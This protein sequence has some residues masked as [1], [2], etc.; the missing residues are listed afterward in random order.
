[1]STPWDVYAKELGDAC[2][3]GY[4]LWDPEPEEQGTVCIGDVG[5]ISEGRFRRL[6]NATRPAN[7]PL[8]TLFGV[9][10]GYEPLQIK[11]QLFEDKEPRMLRVGKSLNSNSITS[12]QVSGG[13]SG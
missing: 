5:Y 9:P 13:A 10:D 7:D 4:P 11:E 6:F 1:M 2:R 8:N 12:T 3:L